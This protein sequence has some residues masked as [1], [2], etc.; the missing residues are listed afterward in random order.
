MEELITR[1]ATSAGIEPD[2]AHQAIA[3]IFGFLQKEAPQAQV[4]SVLVQVPGAQEAANSAESPGLGGLMGLASQLMGLGLGMEQL[5]AAG[6][7][8][9]AYARERTGDETIRE[10]TAAIPGLSQFV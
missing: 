7:E 1:V 9:F 2:V 5:Q 8:L 4:S 10:I 6:K 3:A